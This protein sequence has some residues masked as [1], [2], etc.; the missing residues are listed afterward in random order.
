MAIQDFK[1]KYRYK[2]DTG[3]SKYSYWIA[4]IISVIAF[5]LL[6]TYL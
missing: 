2:S 5:W 3:S 4:I 1:R 6:W